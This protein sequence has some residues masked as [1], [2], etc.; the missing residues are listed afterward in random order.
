[1]KPV[2]LLV[3]IISIGLVSEGTNIP[4]GDVCNCPT[5]SPI[6]NSQ[7]LYQM[8]VLPDIGHDNL[9]SID[10]GQ[11][12][13][14]NFSQCHISKDGKYLHPDGIYLIPWSHW[15]ILQ[16]QYTTWLYWYDPSAKNFNF[17]AN[18]DHHYCNYPSDNFTFHQIC[19]MDSKDNHKDLCTLK[20][21][22]SYEQ[23][24]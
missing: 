11:V 18:I 16:G 7:P 5:K 4:F 3:I 20:P 12:L 1:M 9:H 15:M 13:N 21:K 22:T 23:L 6:D 17:Q 24:N 8:E 10:M 19:T 2:I 14:Y